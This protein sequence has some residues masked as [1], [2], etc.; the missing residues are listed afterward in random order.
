[1]SALAVDLKQVAYRPA[2]NA[3]DIQNI[4]SQIRQYI[5]ILLWINTEVGIEYEGINQDLTTLGP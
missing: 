5:S 4:V 1:M 2:H 3:Q